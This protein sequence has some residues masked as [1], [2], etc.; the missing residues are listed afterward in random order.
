[1]RAAVRQVFPSWSAELEGDVPFMYL[2][3]IGK[4][5]IAIGNLI[6]PLSLAL[7]LPLVHKATGQPAT[8][9][10]IIAEWN[11][12]KSHPHLAEWGHRPAADITNLRLTPDGVVEL[13]RNVAAR[14]WKEL[15]ARFPHN[16][17]WCSDAQLATLSMAWAC[18]TAFNFPVLVRMLNNPDFVGAAYNC[19]INEDG[20]DRRPG[21]EDDNH[22]L[23]PRNHRNKILYRNA[24]VVAKLDLDPEKLYYPDILWPDLSPFVIYGTESQSR[25]AARAALKTEH[26]KAAQARLNAAGFDAGPVDGIFGQRSQGALNAAGGD[27]LDTWAALWATTQP[28]YDLDE[29]DVDLSE[30]NGPLGTSKGIVEWALEQRANDGDEPPPEAA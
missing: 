10:E 21:T 27:N 6:D 28:H 9:S 25:R 14:F 20:P 30:L 26:Y 24:A 23:V 4:V 17:D 11:H 22:G 29:V 5:T 7:D 12:I 1:M 19:N 8:R 13:L 2:D 16:D 18:G 15:R 3:K